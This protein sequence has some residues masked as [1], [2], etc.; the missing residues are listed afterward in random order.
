[1]TVLFGPYGLVLAYPYGFGRK[2]LPSDTV[3]GFDS[4]KAPVFLARI[5]TSIARNTSLGDSKEHNRSLT[6]CSS[7]LSTQFSGEENHPC[8]ERTS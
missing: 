4:S 3:V 8:L 6:E 5:S 7:W 1:M 2:R